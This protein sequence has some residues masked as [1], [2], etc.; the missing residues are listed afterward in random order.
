LAVF[1]NTG[2]QEKVQVEFFLP[3]KVKYGTS[4]YI[5]GSSDALGNWNKSSAVPMQWSEGDVW[6]STFDV[7]PGEKLEY[8]YVIRSTDGKYEKWQNGENLLVHVDDDALKVTVADSWEM[9]KQARKL[10]VELRPEEAQ[11]PQPEIAGLEEGPHPT[12]E[13]LSDKD[14]LRVTFKL[15]KD[16]AF[17]DVLRIAGGCEAFGNWSLDNALALEWTEGNVWTAEALVP[18]R[19]AVEYK[20]VVA[21]SDGSGKADWQGG[22]NLLTPLDTG[23]A[24]VMVTDIWEA[25]KEGRAVE[26]LE[27]EEDSRLAEIEQQ[28]EAV[29]EE[30]SE[31][32]KFDIIT[33]SGKILTNM[34]VQEL[35][36]ECR[37]LGLRPVGRKKDLRVRLSEFLKDVE[38]A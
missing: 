11:A 17:G 32:D 25:G 15:K 3:K 23:G 12:R 30:Q 2:G 7:A 14:I 4:A 27:P 16:L 24:W 18:K 20:Y 5:V 6:Q 19:E 37:Q 36:D 22:P 28:L 13:V 34:T 31:E 1:A 33:P 35:K 9:D 38:V 26:V 21:R 8:K 29:L 10:H